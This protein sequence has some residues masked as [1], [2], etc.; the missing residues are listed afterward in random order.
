[1]RDHALS[2]TDARCIALAARRDRL[3]LSDDR[4]VGTVGCEYDVDVWDLPL[5]LRLAARRGAIESVDEC[6]TL[7]D[8][9]R[10]RDDYRLAPEDRAALL[11]E[12]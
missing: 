1:M 4:H 12:F 7:L 8:D 9:L 6:S 10:R 3:L 11:D 5:F 2:T